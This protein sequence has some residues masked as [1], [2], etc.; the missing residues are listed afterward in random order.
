M[1]QSRRAVESYWRSKMID[2]AT[3]DEDKVTPVYKLEEICD[4]LRSSHISIVKEVSQFIL[5]RLDHKS[6]IV[7]QKA[8]RVIK[9]AVG[10]S[11]AE[12]KREMQKNSVSVRQLIHYRGQPDPLKGD[13]LNKAVR[14][15]AQETLS[16]L[17]SSDDSTAA[18]T[19]SSLRSR[20]QGFGNTNYEMPSDDRKSF[21]SE[22]VDIGSA[23]IRQGFSNLK[24]SPSIRKSNDTGSYRSPNLERSLTRE[25]D[26][27][28]RYEG[29]GSHAEYNSSSRFSK[30]AGNGSWDEEI[31]TSQSE[32]SN[33]DPALT[34]SQKTREEKLLETIVTSTGVRLQPTR[35]ALHV[36][37]VEASKL[38][39]KSL[40]HAIEMKLRS[41]MWQVRMKA[42]CILE[43]LLRK[44]ND[45]HF[46]LIASYFDDNKDVVVQCSESPQASLRE[47]A[48]KVL[49]LLGCEQNGTGANR[50]KQSTQIPQPSVIPDMINTGDLDDLGMEDP[51]KAACEPKITSARPS[52]APLINDLLGNN[53]DGCESTNK[54]N[55]DDDPFADVSFLISQDLDRVEDLLSGM[56][57]D[58]PGASEAH[59][60]AHENDSE[61]FNLLNS[62][63]EVFMEQGNSGEYAT[64]LMDGMPVSGNDHSVKVNASSEEM[65]G[66]ILGSVSSADNRSPNVALNNEFPLQAAEVNVNP[67]FPLGA[68]TYNIPSGFVLNPAFASQPINYNA[69]G[70]HFAQQQFLAAMSNFHLLGNLQSSSTINSPGPVGGN[71][72]PLPDIFNP[73]IATQPPTSLMNGSKR[74]DTKAFDFISDHLASARETKRTI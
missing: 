47:K 38:D 65:G 19:E 41:P 1:E 27:S 5:R 30:N 24:Q 63:S 53:S 28:D 57:F 14:E 25:S 55:V 72:S 23:T 16:T 45:G 74:E 56:A 54:L 66:K 64:N 6:P 8:L 70:S 21:I 71:V 31:S 29:I 44:K 51:E 49:S 37:L 20:I 4:L 15:T 50:V 48:T 43:A 7:K 13:A 58:K 61:P 69:M 9:Y 2:V 3:S 39:A 59:V 34:Y 26:Y 32:T 36:F 18:P 73:G 52:V 40:A 60:A 17:F 46:S 68:V 12:F 42:I 10:K 62:S 35:D 11:G 67:I 33:G 22:V